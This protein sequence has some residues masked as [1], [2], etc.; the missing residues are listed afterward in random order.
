MFDERLVYICTVKEGSVK[1]CSHHEA[2]WTGRGVLSV[3]TPPEVR[4]GIE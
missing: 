2:D 3:V 4:I 1:N